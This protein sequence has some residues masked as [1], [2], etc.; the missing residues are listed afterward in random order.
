MSES[1]TESRRESGWVWL[2]P[3]LVAALAIGLAAAHLPSRVRLLVLFPVAIT[4][5]SMKNRFS[6]LTNDQHAT[7]S[8]LLPSL[9][10]AFNF[11]YRVIGVEF[12]WLL[13][14]CNA[15]TQQR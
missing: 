2:I 7:E 14:R 15:A 9:Q 12:V 10:A 11:I 8:F 3:A 13:C 1:P 4:V 6:T 5:G